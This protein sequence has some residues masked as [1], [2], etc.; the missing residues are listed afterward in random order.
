MGECMH[1]EFIDWAREILH[2]TR[3]VF[4]VIT[5]FSFFDWVIDLQGEQLY[6]RADFGIAPAREGFI[7]LHHNI[8]HPY[9]G[10]V[11][12]LSQ[13][14]ASSPFGIRIETLWGHIETFEN[15]RTHFTFPHE[16]LELPPLVV[17]EHRVLSRY[18]FGHYFAPG[19][20][21]SHSDPKVNYTE[22]WLARDKRYVINPTEGIV[23]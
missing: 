13:D 20:L 2:R 16:T 15:N 11:G 7:V 9:C 19:G 4:E 21:T 8:I 5:A 22:Q 3:N 1:T 12:M 23:F 10:N 14:G 6:A 17:A 18:W